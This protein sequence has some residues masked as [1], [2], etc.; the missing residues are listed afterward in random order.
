MCFIVIAILSILVVVIIGMCLN[1]SSSPIFKV[2]V[3]ISVSVPIII[4]SQ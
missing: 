4:A 1:L 3:P 2:V